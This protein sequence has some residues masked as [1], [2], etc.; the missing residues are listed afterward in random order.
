MGATVVAKD[1]KSW[2]YSAS[3]NSI[4]IPNISYSSN[5]NSSATMASRRL[6]A[7]RITQ[8]HFVLLLV[9]TGP[10][11]GCGPGRRSVMVRRHRK[12]TPLVFKQHY[13]NFS[14]FTLAASG[15][16]EGRITRG[17]AR[18]KELV[19]NENSDIIF[20]DEEGTGADRMMTQPV[21]T[22]AD[23]MNHDRRLCACFG[24]DH[25]GL[26]GC[27][28]L[29]GVRGRMLRVGALPPARRS[30]PPPKYGV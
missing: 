12:M 15:V 29:S 14:E 25:Y 11:L 13:P 3:P 18:F 21:Q 7:N 23:F 6:T 27:M 28:L 30:G 5:N 4:A 20:R 26:P 9:L 16:P 17:D 24:V 2:K 10:S 1:V 22:S 19:R 8:L